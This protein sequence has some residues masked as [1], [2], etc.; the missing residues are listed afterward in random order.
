MDEC[1]S[2]TFPFSTGNS[3]LGK[4]RQK[5]P[6]SCQFKLKFGIETNLN[7]Q[8]SMTLFTFSVLEHKHPFWANLVKKSQNCQF[9]LKFGT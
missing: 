3:F 6:Q 9:K 4:F 8:N 1:T 5:K 7:M 2:A